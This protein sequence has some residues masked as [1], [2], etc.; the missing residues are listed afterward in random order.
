MNL[1]MSGQFKIQL[2]ILL[3]LTSKPHTKKK[4]KKLKKKGKNVKS[5]SN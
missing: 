3:G 4:K 5:H 2:E 1:A